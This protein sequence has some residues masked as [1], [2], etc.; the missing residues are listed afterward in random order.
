M[1][2]FSLPL[3]MCGTIL[4][5][6]LAACARQPQPARIEEITFRSGEFTIVGELR[7]PEGTGP[8]PVVLFVHGSGPADR[9]GFGMYLP[10]M[11]RLQQ[12]GYAT[13]AWDKPGTGESTGSLENGHVHSQRAQILLD[14]I[15]VLKAHPNIDP[16][17]IGLW[18][19]SQAGYVMPRA[20][21]QSKDIAFMICVSCPGM[22]SYDQMAF[23]VTAFALCD[24]ASEEKADEQASLLAELD[25]ARTYETYAE[26]L[27]YREVLEAL[28]G[29]A[30]APVEKWPILAKEAWQEGDPDREALWNP[31]EVIEQ[32]TI[33]VLAIFGDRDRN[34]DPLQGA[35]AYRVALEG[36]GNLQSRVEVFPKANHGIAVSETGCP[37]D[38]LQWLEQSAKSLGYAS[39][40]EAQEALQK[41]A[42]NHELLSKIPYAPGYLDTMDEWLRD[43]QR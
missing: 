14:A 37:D 36:A 32:T 42:S 2:Q 8:F 1:K 23:Q 25:Q 27:Y 12:A 13:F 21:A 31:I 18:G 38:D 4:A 33:P 15:E 9:T 3:M 22:S 41:G 40:G 16:G 26:Y 30:P 39:I 34:I 29:L 7:T 43:L 19:I 35:H 24:G 17:Q 6:L 10:V 28:A 5:L 11:E 20:L